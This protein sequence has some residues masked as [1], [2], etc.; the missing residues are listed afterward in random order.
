MLV[1]LLISGV[2]EDRDVA[3]HVVAVCED[4]VSAA[5]D[6]LPYFELHF[7]AL[8]WASFLWGDPRNNALWPREGVSDILFTRSN[9]VL[10]EALDLH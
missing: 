3:R 8:L 2:L 10:V 7:H 4:E 9:Q 5:S 1:Q 6:K